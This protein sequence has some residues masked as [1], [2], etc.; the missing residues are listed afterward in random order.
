MQD[1]LNPDLQEG[2]V[3]M[4]SPGS[5]SG[6]ENAPPSPAPFLGLAEHWHHLAGPGDP[7]QKY[8]FR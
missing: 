8:G 3:C 5:F 4:V 1:S 6:T 2:G 7:S